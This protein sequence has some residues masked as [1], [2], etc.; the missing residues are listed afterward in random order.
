MQ[1]SSIIAL[2]LA[3][4]LPAVAEDAGE[5]NNYGG[6][7]STVYGANAYADSSAT[8]YDGYAQA[9]RYLGW[10]VECNGGSNRYFQQDSHSHS[11]SGDEQQYGNNFCQRY[12]VWAA[13]SLTIAE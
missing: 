4:I 7:G 9:W 12:L 5:S 11:G 1:F 6:G 13:V 8:Y 3:T 2:C 10:Y